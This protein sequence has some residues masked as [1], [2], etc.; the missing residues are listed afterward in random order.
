MRSIQSIFCSKHTWFI[1]YRSYGV[2][3]KW[4]IP[5]YFNHTKRLHAISR[6]ASCTHIHQ[7]A[8]TR[9]CHIIWEFN[10]NVR[11]QQPSVALPLLPTTS[12]ARQLGDFEEQKKE[13]YIKNESMEHIYMDW[14]ISDDWRGFCLPAVQRAK[15]S[16]NVETNT[17]REK[18]KWEKYWLYVCY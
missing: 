12:F 5:F 6:H 14:N 13:N 16:V 18:N 2:A 4:T 9:T 3:R 17:W 8:S 7:L 1:R 11:T 10:C 15:M